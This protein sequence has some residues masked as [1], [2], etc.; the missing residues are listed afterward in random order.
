MI[1]FGRKRRQNAR[2]GGKEIQT[3]LPACQ[4]VCLKALAEW[5]TGRRLA[6]YLTNLANLRLFVEDPSLRADRRRSVLAREAF[7]TPDTPC[8]SICVVRPEVLVASARV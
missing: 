5:L 3:S 1:S 4:L 2:E 7:E 8:R 6:D